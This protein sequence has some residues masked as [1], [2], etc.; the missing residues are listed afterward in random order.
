MTTYKDITIY[1][2]AKELNLSP[3][4]VSR[5]L[6]NNPIINVGTRKKVM[7][8]AAKKGYRS[9]AFASNLRTQKTN[10]I[11]VIAHELNSYFIT[12]VLAG[13]EEVATEAGYDILIAHSNETMTK[14]RTNAHN[15]F[16]KRVDGVI[17]SLA[18]DTNN[19]S[20]FE[21]FIKK[22]IPLLFFDRIDNNI[23]ATQV[24]IDNFQAGYDAT[25]HLIEQ[26]CTQIVHA[27]A[28]LNRN[29]YA[30]R[31]LGYKK[32]LK[33][34]KIPYK[35]SL[36]LVDDFSED[37]GKL[38][39]EKILKMNPL[40]DGVFITNDFSAAVCMSRLKEAGIKI[41]QDMAIVGFNNDVISRIVEPK[42]TTINYPGKLMG[43][44][45]AERL[46]QQL[47]T[48]KDINKKEQ[49]IIPSSLIIR[50]SSLRKV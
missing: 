34:Y 28:S 47:Q 35:Q 8:L 42:I 1:D 45:I 18:Y 40:P 23:A 49:I 19:L 5:A 39:A 20:H 41:P 2:L 12:A 30:D 15:L 38:I 33:D 11:G 13:I 17:A 50:D 46:V 10:T 32:A 25:Q 36:V 27:T 29:V 26:G 37:S 48:K 44:T 9:N 16:N 31:L 6:K 24:V 3:A 43:Q 7:D 22:H 21:P 4:T 14:E